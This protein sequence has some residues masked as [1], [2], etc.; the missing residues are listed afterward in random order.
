MSILLL[1]KIILAISNFPLFYWLVKRFSNYTISMQTKS[2]ER[3]AF[4]ETRLIFQNQQDIPVDKEI[5]IRLK[6]SKEEWYN[7]A[8]QTTE[9]QEEKP[10]AVSIVHGPLHPK[11]K[12]PNISFI[13]SAN[14][15]SED[16]LITFPEG[17][18]SFATWM[19]I[20]RTKEEEVKLHSL[21]VDG[22]VLK[23]QRA[24]KK[25]NRRFSLSSFWRSQVALF[26][27]FLVLI[28]IININLEE[29][30]EGIDLNNFTAFIGQVT[31]PYFGATLLLCLV[32]TSVF[33]FSAI[34]I[35]TPIKPNIIM[36][37]LDEKDP[38]STT[39]SE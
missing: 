39:H 26:F 21:E 38:F 20:C 29:I 32:I 22:D 8:E 34:R 27:F 16:C 36:G 15:R 6:M 2:I 5:K 3:D 9:A 30:K 31:G 25:K 35:C 19:L 28:F 11:S 17:V 1:I 14:P 33:S 7:A 12:R 10:K 23:V 4:R 13:E 24:E 18:R 37:Y